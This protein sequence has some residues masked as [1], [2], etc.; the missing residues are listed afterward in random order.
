M[1]TGRFEPGT[2]VSISGATLQILRKVGDDLWQFEDQKTKRIVELDQTAILTKLADQELTLVGTGKLADCG[3]ANLHLTGER[4]EEA[5]VRLAYVL[6]VL[7]VPNTRK[8]FEVVIAS[9]WKKLQQP[10]KPPSFT[11]VYLWKR[12]YLA[13]RKDIRALVSNHKAKGNRTSRYGAEVLDVCARSIKF[14]YMTRER[15]TFQDVID[16]ARARVAELNEQLPPSVALKMPTRRLLKRLVGN[17]PAFDKHAAR[18]GRESARN[19]FRG[20]KGHIVTDAPLERAEIDHTC[21]DLFVIDDKHAL[22]LGRP[23]VTACI[24]HYT[25]CIL[26]IYV[27]FIPPSF[28]TVAKCLKNCFEP[29]VNLRTLYPEIKNEWDA[30]GVMKELVLDNGQ[31]FHSISLEQVCLSLGIVMRYSPRKEPQAK[32]HIERWLGTMNRAVA[33]GVPGTTFSNIFEKDDYD[34]AKQAI[35]TI[36]E[37][38]CR[39]RKWIVDVY[40]QKPHSAL[41]TSPAQMWRS[42]ISFEDIN[43]ADETTQLQAILG[44]VHQRTL[45]HKGIELH[46]LLYNSPELTELRSRIGNGVE[47]EI[48]VDES[49]L[50]SIYALSPMNSVPYLVPCINSDYASGISLWQHKLLRKMQAKL[51]PEEPNAL[52]Y[53]KAKRDM[54]KMIEDELSGGKKRSRKRVARY[55]EHSGTSTDQPK[56]I[57]SLPKSGPVSGTA[58]ILSRDIAM[59]DDEDDLTGFIPK[60]RTADIHG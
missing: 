22:P 51:F 7:R 3:S 29:K 59:E 53:V 49:D 44:R 6:E 35:V 33:H 43:V 54:N 9:V 39:I 42:S 31:E 40:H 58:P 16:D 52:G 25:R 36:S 8:A 50:G 45:S 48:R 56:A 11:A 38:Q 27:G 24:D 2:I 12:R 26:G 37:L 34:P 30:Y 46:G 41:Y 32:P 21:L 28:L 55:R 57:D 18:H 23:Y 13:A 4:F 60:I 14:K 17:I 20:V 5:K 1:G 47:V 19:A 10:S 15:C